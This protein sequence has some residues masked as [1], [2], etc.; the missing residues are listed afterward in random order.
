MIAPS[1]GLVALSAE[2]RSSGNCCSIWRKHALMAA[3]CRSFPVW[4]ARHADMNRPKITAAINNS[5]LR[6]GLFREAVV[7]LLAG[8][9]QLLHRIDADVEI[10]SCRAVEL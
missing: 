4:S 2:G 5:G 6:N 1:R 7:D 10:L 9:K 3:R 8:L